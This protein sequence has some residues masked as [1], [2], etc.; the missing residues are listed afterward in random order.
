MT[1]ASQTLRPSVLLDTAA[2]RSR[3]F[4]MPV[5][6][7][8]V[9]IVLMGIILMRTH[10]SDVWGGPV[11]YT[12]TI[13]VTLFQF[14]RIGMAAWYSRSMDDLMEI[15]SEEPYLPKV[16]FVIPCL[17]EENSIA[18]TI[19]KCYEANYPDDKIEVI[20]INDGSTDNTFWVVRSL[21]AHFPGLTVVNWEKN[22]GKRQAMAEG[23]RLA[24]GEIV[25]QI[26]SDSYIE[27]STFQNLIQPFRNPEVGAVCA[28]ADP[29][30]ADKNVVTRMQAAYYFMSFRIMKAAESTLFTVFCCSGCSSAYRRSAVMPVL[31]DWLNERFLGK[32]ATWGDDRSLTSWVLKR[33]YRTVYTDRVQAY[34]I[35]PDTMRK[36]LRQQL[37]WKK[38]WIVNA[39][40]TSKFIHRKQPFVAFAYYFPLLLISFL[41]PLVVFRSLVYATAVHQVL[42]LYYLLGVFLTTTLVLLYYRAV[43]PENKHWPYLYLWSLLNMFVLSFVLVFAAFRLNDRSWG[44]R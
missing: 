12:Y 25:V 43:A 27:P 14:S 44:T 39:F 8:G 37:R 16:T 7:L 32:P 21:K 18:K 19:V 24:K 4:S 13:F 29:S 33:D 20:V 38:S 15:A 1:T 5:I 17:N 9:A 34:T 41:T 31:D 26:D 11:V 3:R 40:F 22:R 30:N 23:F 2:P 36:L 35:V 28:H 6:A 10:S 42:P